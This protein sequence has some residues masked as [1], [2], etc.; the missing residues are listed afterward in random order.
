MRI[1]VW[2]DLVCPWCFIGK[3][4][5]QRALEQFEDNDDVTTQLLDSCDYLDRVNADQ[6]TAREPSASGVPFFVFNNAMSLSVA[7]PVAAFQ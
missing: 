3:K 7:Q 4:R 6:A 2:A 5:L 1:D